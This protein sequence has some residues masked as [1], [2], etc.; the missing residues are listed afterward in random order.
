MRIE[1]LRSLSLS[2]SYL[3]FELGFPRVFRGHEGCSKLCLHITTKEI[4]PAD[5]ASQARL[6]RQK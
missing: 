3:K 4:R 1:R 5:S 2:S 6:L